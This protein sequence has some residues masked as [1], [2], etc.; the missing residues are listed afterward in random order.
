MPREVSK[1]WWEFGKQERKDESTLEHLIRK[2][3]PEQYLS[4]ILTRLE[5]NQVRYKE[6]DAEYLRGLA[7]YARTVL[8]E[9]EKHLPKEELTDP[10]TK[11]G[12]VEMYDLA[13]EMEEYARL[14]VSRESLIE[15]LHQL[16]I[17]FER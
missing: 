1:R 5:R 6:S 12:L 7:V 14:V 8:K 13:K 17:D 11:Q 3:E 15:M 4:E 2:L 16:K 9:Y 10:L